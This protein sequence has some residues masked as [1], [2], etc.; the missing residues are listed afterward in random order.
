MKKFVLVLLLGAN[1]TILGFSQNV[2]V[3]ETPDITRLVEKHIELNRATQTID[4]WRIQLFAT[5]DRAKL[6]S[7]R[8]TFIN[9]YPSIPVDWE[10]ASPWY[11]LRAG[12]YATKLDATRMLNSLKI[13]YPDAYLAKDKIRPSEILSSGI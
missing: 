6:E 11:R 3:R 8:G 12:A 10:H 9:R 2:V 7:A 13:Y 1:F 4:G 5:T